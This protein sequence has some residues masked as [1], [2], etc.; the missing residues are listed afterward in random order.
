[1]RVFSK[2]FSDWIL[3][4]S[5]ALEMALVCVFEYEP[6]VKSL[7]LFNSRPM[8]GALFDLP[9]FPLMLN[10]LCV[11]VYTEMSGFRFD[12]YIFLILI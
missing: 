8:G 2:P 3:H 11:C 4:T 9:F 7:L 1:M 12:I 6:N 10:C 5:V